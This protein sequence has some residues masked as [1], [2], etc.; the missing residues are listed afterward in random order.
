MANITPGSYR[1]K[2]V[3]HQFGKTSNDNEKIRVTFDI[4]EGEHKGKRLFWEGFFTEATVD[5]T[6]ESL[7]Y[8][9][10]DGES[11]T[12]MKGLGTQEVILVVE[13]EK[14][15]DG[16]MYLKVR[17]VNRL[18]SRKL[19]NA[20]DASDVRSLEE[21]IKAIMLDRRQKREESGDA[22]FDYGGNEEGPPV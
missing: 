1:A 13:N 2:A 18:A 5:R 7:E 4:A 12:E 10:W 15:T 22:S 21:R 14:G 6:L 3:E 19:K 20:I 11:L 16:K 9:G 17:W 8:C